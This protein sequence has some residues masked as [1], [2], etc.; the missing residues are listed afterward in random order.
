MKANLKA[1]LFAAAVTSVLLASGCATP[2]TQVQSDPIV[3]ALTGK[4][5]AWLQAHLGL[6]NEREDYDTGNML[7]VYRDENKGIQASSCRVSLSIRNGSVERVAIDTERHALVS[8]AR[9]P[10]Q[11]IR[12]SVQRGDST[13]VAR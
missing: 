7:W 6:P 1:T 5:T 9:N 10:C 12:D 3:D 11:A 4:P 13:L 8:L 2:V